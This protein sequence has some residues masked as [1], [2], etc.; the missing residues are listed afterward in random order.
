MPTV[1]LAYV[2][3]QPPQQPPPLPPAP[4][5]RRKP[6]PKPFFEVRRGSFILFA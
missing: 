3:G 4:K 6:K 5:K 2:T 1:P